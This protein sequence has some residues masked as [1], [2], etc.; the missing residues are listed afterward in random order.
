MKEL[1]NLHNSK[2][3]IDNDLSQAVNAM[4]NK[5]LDNKYTDCLLTKSH[6]TS[7]G[8]SNNYIYEIE[9]EKLNQLLNVKEINIFLKKFNYL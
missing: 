4:N 1:N 5:T 7:G 8:K 9:T 6:N 2:N 3:L